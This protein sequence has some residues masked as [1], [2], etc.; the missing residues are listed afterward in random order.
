[1]NLKS[2]QYLLMTLAAMLLATPAFAQGGA[3]AAKPVGSA[4]GGSGHGAGGGSV[5]HWPGTGDG[6]GHGGAG[7]QSGGATGDLYLFDFG[8]GVY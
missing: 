8:S 7:A 1:M 2:L 4:G 5:R 6:F 3:E